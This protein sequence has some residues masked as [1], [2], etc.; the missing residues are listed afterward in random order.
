MALKISNHCQSLLSRALNQLRP[1]SVNISAALFKTRMLVIASRCVMCSYQSILKR[2]F[3]LI[4]INFDES[5]HSD[6]RNFYFPW[7]SCKDSVS[8]FVRHTISFSVSVV[9]RKVIA[10]LVSGQCFYMVYDW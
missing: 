1:D 9:I 5:M 7:I 10:S 2:S 4:K 6:P 8:P 3:V